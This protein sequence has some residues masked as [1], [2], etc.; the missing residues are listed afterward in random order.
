MIILVIVRLVHE[1]IEEH[2]FS[3]DNH[4]FYEDGYDGISCEILKSFLNQSQ[5]SISINVGLTDGFSVGP[6]NDLLFPIEVR[7]NLNVINSLFN[8]N[9]DLICYSLSLTPTL[10]S[11]LR[12]IVKSIT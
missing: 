11:L 2:I 7:L 1:V 10:L 4:H 8:V 3:R 5:I 6:T 9:S 12:K